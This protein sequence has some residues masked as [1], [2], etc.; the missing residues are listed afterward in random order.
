MHEEWLFYQANQIDVALIRATTAD[1]AGILSMERE[2]LTLDSLP[3]QWQRE[4]QVAWS[5]RR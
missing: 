2:A 5:L 3:W 1:M 4:M